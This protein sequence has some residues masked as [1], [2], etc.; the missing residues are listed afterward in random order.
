[1]HFTGIGNLHLKLKDTNVKMLALVFI[2]Y[3]K[4]SRRSH[5]RIIKSPQKN[6]VLE[7]LN[8]RTIIVVKKILN[9]GMISKLSFNI[10]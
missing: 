4:R 2:V 5:V 9:M 7:Y 6:D 8:R 10:Y 1:M 3:I